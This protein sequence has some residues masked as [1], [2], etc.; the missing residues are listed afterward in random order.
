[1]HK[2]TV[3]DIDVN[4]TE[5]I[6][7]NGTLGVTEMPNFTKGTNAMIN[8]LVERTRAGATTIIGE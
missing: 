8:I 4:G 7:W 6:M 3:H 1:M 2:K 5:T